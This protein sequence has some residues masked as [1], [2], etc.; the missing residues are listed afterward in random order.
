MTQL[1][2]DTNLAKYSSASTGAAGACRSLH[3]HIGQIL[4]DPETL[5]GQILRPKAWNNKALIL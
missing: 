2:G 4:S 5:Y 1:A 3:H